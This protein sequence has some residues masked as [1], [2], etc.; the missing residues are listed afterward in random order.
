M[1][2][3]LEIRRLCPVRDVQVKGIWSLLSALLNF[4]GLKLCVS[5]WYCSL[6]KSAMYAGVFTFNEGHFFYCEGPPCTSLAFLSICIGF[7][8]KL[9][10]LSRLIGFRSFCLSRPPAFS[11]SHVFSRYLRGVCATLVGLSEI[12]HQRPTK[13][14]K[15]PR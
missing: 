5:E 3:A 9:S 7:L 13:I 14:A 6:F 10:S 12:P 15:R 11:F 2:V 1:M 8:I 4:A